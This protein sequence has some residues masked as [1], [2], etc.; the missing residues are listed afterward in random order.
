MGQLRPTHPAQ[1]HHTL[2][3]VQARLHPAQAQAPLLALAP[4]TSPRHHLL[5][6]HPFRALIHPECSPSTGPFNQNQ[7]SLLLPPH[8][9]VWTPTS[10]NH[11]N[12]RVKLTPRPRQARLLLHHDPDQKAWAVKVLWA[13]CNRNQRR[14]LVQQQ[15][16][17][18]H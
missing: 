9:E 10:R 17:A 12:L 7:I 2:A 14:H 6:A 8:E 4:C 15:V 5:R 3:R 13:V 16:R 1:I 18:H 11:F